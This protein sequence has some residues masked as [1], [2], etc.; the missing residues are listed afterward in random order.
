MGLQTETQ[1]GG[2]TYGLLTLHAA[3]A[4]ASVLTAPLGMA[5]L[6]TPS[7][8]MHYIQ[9]RLDLVTLPVGQ[10]GPKMPRAAL[11]PF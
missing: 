2:H 1:H 3:L 5:P 4:I 11:A 7:F 9:V 8:H 10:Y 6:K